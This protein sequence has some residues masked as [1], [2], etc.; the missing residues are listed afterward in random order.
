[1]AVGGRY[2]VRGKRERRTTIFF[3]VVLGRVLGRGQVACWWGVFASLASFCSV[4]VRFGPFWLLLVRF[5]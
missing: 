3:C 5:V 4:L 2:K 1:M